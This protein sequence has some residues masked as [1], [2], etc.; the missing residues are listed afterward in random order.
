VFKSTVVKKELSPTWPAFEI[1]LEKLCNGNRDRPLLVEVYDWDKNSADDLIGS[2]VTTAAEMVKGG[3]EHPVVHPGKKKYKNYENS[4]H[5]SFK[6]LVNVEEVMGPN[7]VPGKLK[8]RFWQNIRSKFVKY[9]AGGCEVSI[10]FGIDFTG[11]NGECTRPHSRHYLSEK[12]NHYQQ[13]I[14]VVGHIVE[15]YDHDKKFPA[16]GYGASI[17]GG[18]FPDFFNLLHFQ[19]QVSP[20][21][22]KATCDGIEGV[23]SAYKEVTPTL[24]FGD[25]KTAEH[26]GG[27]K[28]RGDDF[29]QL[30]KVATDYVADVSQEKQ[31]YSLLLLVIDGDV[32]DN[33]AT[34][35]AIVEA[36]NKALSIVIVGVGGSSWQGSRF[37]NCRRFDADKDPLKHSNGQLMERDVVQF[38]PFDS[39]KDNMARLAEEV[40][41][42]LPAQL[43][44]YMR[45]KK[46]NPN[47]RVRVEL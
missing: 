13:A 39:F 34:I 44:Q 43:V 33:Q 41:R 4:G 24:G 1:T 40:L 21:D 22:T 36:G 47:P 3:A 42:E 32:F 29:Y 30:I 19:E 2:F 37:D 9:I 28:Y 5:F 12:H 11:S 18:R 14:E 25:M 45:G 10:V 27:G 7:P 26:P 31:A 16:F 38:V 17:K 20:K 8:A 23:L 6:C 15:K 35:D 46:I